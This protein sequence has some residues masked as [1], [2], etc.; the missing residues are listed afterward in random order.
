MK[1]VFIP[2]LSIILLFCLA[3]CNDI[4]DIEDV[5]ESIAGSSEVVKVSSAK[6]KVVILSGQSNAAGVSHVDTLSQT[7]ADKYAA[8]FENVLISV[9]NAVSGHN[10]DGFVKTTT[11]WGDNEE[12][13]WFGPEVGLAEALSTAYPGEK[14]YII[15][16]SWSGAGLED[17]FLPG[18]TAYNQL[19]QAVDDG[20]SQLRE[21][22]LDPE[23]IAFCWMQGETDACLRGTAKRYKSN[24]EKMGNSLRDL[25]GQ[26]FFID[27]G[28]SDSWKFYTK[29]NTSK[30]DMDC[31][32]ERCVFINS[33]YF[34]LKVSDFDIAHYDAPSMLKLGHLFGEQIAAHIMNE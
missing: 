27:A 1:K 26:F 19:C 23:V 21:Q 34:G 10:S 16:Y 24:Q 31:S 30:R 29:V 3:S 8:G 6:T 32:T 20:L 22:G 5:R 11:G 25:Y 14:I 12:G 15:K 33:N 13:V 18:R 17:L 2:L 7:D 4:L 28:I 9:T